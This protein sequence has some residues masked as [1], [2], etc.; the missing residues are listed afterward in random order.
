MSLYLPSAA[1]LQIFTDALETR[2]CLPV[3]S[4]TDPTADSLPRPSAE[5]IEVAEGAFGGKFS[6]PLTLTA[7][8]QLSPASGRT[9]GHS[10]THAAIEVW[11]ITPGCYDLVLRLPVAAAAHPTLMAPLAAQ[12]SDRAREV[13][14]ILN[15]LDYL[16]HRSGVPLSLSGAQQQLIRLERE[17][18]TRLDSDG[19][20]FLLGSN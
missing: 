1:G 17:S 3:A 11:A 4:T 20:R 5:V 19:I 18:G 14:R 8:T 6:L 2:L 15:N 7:G 9:V 13:S 10:H 16:R 12:F